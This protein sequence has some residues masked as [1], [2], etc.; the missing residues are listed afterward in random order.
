VQ[1]HPMS[2]SGAGTHAGRGALP[3]AVPTAAA[4]YRPDIDGLRAVAVLSVVLH[5]LSASLLPGGYVGVD[6]FFVIS[7]YLITSIISRE[8][9]GGRFTFRRFYER[10]AR[11]IFP[12]L[13]AMLAVTL[14]AGQFLIL[15][16]DYAATLRAA[17]GTVFFSS[18]LVFWRVKTGYFDPETR[19]NPLLHTWSLGV[20]EQFYLLFPVFL[21]V[22]YRFWRKHI[23][24]T[25]LLCA[26]VS[27]V[28][29]M[30]L[31]RTHRAA[32]FYLS[33]FRAWE[34]L[35]GSLLAFEAVPRVRSRLVRELLVAGGLTA[36]VT[37]CLVYGERT[38]FPGLTALAPV[39]GAVA[40]I[41]AGASGATLAGRLLQWRPMV[42]IGL[43]SYSLYLWHWPLIV[44]GQY[45][46]GMDMPTPYLLFAMSVLVA[47][48]SYHLVEQPFRR[49]PRVMPPWILPSTAGFVLVVSVFCVA[50]LASDGF[51]GR[52]DAKVVRLDKF[53][54]PSI[55]YVNCSERPIQA[56]C[57]LG[58]PDSEPDIL[59]WGDS[60]VLALAPALQA[61]LVQAR[62]KAVLVTAS[63]CP[64]FFDV[65][66][67]MRTG[68]GAASA[69]VKSYLIAHPQ[70]KTIVLAGWW[71]F[72]FND[73]GPLKI[74]L[75]KGSTIEGVAAAK[76]SLDMTLK[77]LEANGR[78]VILIGSVPVYSK[79]VPAALALE[80]L[81]GRKALDLSASEQRRK[82]ALF[83]AQVDGFP[84]GASF[85]YLDPIQWLC[86]QECEVIKDDVPLYRDANHLSIA[87]AMALQVKLSEGLALSPGRSGNLAKLVRGASP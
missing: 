51:A 9:A 31:V 45:A 15:P 25:L 56:P 8:M 63:V 72:Y 65:E 64:P 17:L 18:N 24:G 11:R 42:Y 44:L 47:S 77:W 79:N 75:E 49:G 46:N 68:C 22:C 21:L 34:L 81:T 35:A 7:G 73:A 62:R 37:A 41:H 67:A 86:P 66:N 36:I 59:V 29:A 54:S 23:F 71:S 39:L 50:G 43:I 74:V 82:H 19:L 52:F 13:F 33:P 60:H 48:I 85:R 84:R 26:A 12:A 10:R 58:R 6:V 53:R 5:H 28:W 61:S 70:I 38:T 14:I 20:E 40:I 55:P 87:G 83:Q 78:T 2:H 69:A 32:A 16:S 27:L 76:R 30:F 57:F 1:A 80:A 4:A 3:E